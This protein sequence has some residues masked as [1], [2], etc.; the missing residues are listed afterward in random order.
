MVIPV[1][2]ITTIV[3]TNTIVIIEKKLPF[4]TSKQ[5]NIPTPAGTKKKAR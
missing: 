1:T 5:A 2:A 3:E 4:I